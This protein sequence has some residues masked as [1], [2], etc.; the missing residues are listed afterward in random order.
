V[1]VS[2]VTFANRRVPEEWPD[3][4]FDLIV[5][6]EMLYYLDSDDLTKVVARATNA[7]REDGSV[8][9]VHYLGETDY[10]MTGDAAA[11]LFIA[12]SKLELVSQ[13]REVAYRIDVLARSI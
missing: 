1:A 8:L 9:L 6:S 3:G 10:P 4:S 5:M 13:R 12:E 11:D 2:N 7:L